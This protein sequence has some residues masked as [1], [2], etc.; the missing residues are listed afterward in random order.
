MAADPLRR[1]VGH[2]IHSPLQ[3]PAQISA[4][5]ERVVGHDGNAVPAGHLHD[6]LEIGNVKFRIADRLQVNRFGLVVDQ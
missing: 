4:G 3:R 5:A 2:H 6:R 1:R